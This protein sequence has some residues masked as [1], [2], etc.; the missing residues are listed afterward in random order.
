MYCGQQHGLNWQYNINAGSVLAQV[1]LHGRNSELYNDLELAFEL[2]QGSKDFGNGLTGNGRNVISIKFEANVSDKQ[3]WG[4]IAQKAV[5]EMNRLHEQ[6][7][8]LLG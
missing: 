2:P 3:Q 4:A 6:I 7:T 1:H 8:A 5:E